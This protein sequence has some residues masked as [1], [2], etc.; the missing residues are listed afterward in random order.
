M[1]S[2]EILGEVSPAGLQSETGRLLAQ[3]QAGEVVAQ[4]LP[5]LPVAHGSFSDPKDESIKSAHHTPLEVSG[6]ARNLHRQKLWPKSRLLGTISI[7]ITIGLKKNTKLL[8]SLSPPPLDFM[9]HLISI[10]TVK[11]KKSQFSEDPCYRKCGCK[12]SS[13][14][15]ISALQLSPELITLSLHFEARR[16]KTKTGGKKTQQIK[17]P[18]K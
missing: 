5:H 15:S 2:R 8:L 1:K 9:T 4:M 17:R 7:Q 3:K 10:K 13:N 18:Q 6:C 11:W 16:L 12:L 14:L